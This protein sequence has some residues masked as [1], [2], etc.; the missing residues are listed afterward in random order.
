MHTNGGV[1]CA[2]GLTSGEQM[3]GSGSASLQDISG[4]SPNAKSAVPSTQASM[5][6]L[7]ATNCHLKEKL[8]EVKSNYESVCDENERLGESLRTAN[9]EVRKA[10]ERA[11]EATDA[12]TVLEGLLEEERRARR[13][14]VDKR[15]IAEREREEGYK[16]EME[17]LSERMRVAQQR[18]EEVENEF[19]SSASTIEDLQAAVAAGH[20]R[21]EALER[22]T[23]EVNEEM[24]A[25]RSK[26][27][28][29][30]AERL[31]LE[32]AAAELRSEC[33]KA[34]GEVSSLQ[35][36]L[37]GKLVDEETLK[38]NLVALQEERDAL[39]VTGG[40]I[41]ELTSNIESLQKD[42]SVAK[43][44][45]TLL[46]SEKDS[47][48]ASLRKDKETLQN[49]VKNMTEVQAEREESHET[50][51]VA[52]RQSEEELASLRKECLTAQEQCAATQ[53]KCDEVSSSLETS[54][55]GSLHL[56]A[57]ICA[58]ERR[59]CELEEE[60]RVER[61]KAKAVQEDHQKEVAAMR[62]DIK[63]SAAAL[64][65]EEAELQGAR[66]EYTVLHSSYQSIEE[67]LS[68]ARAETIAVREQLEQELTTGH[69][70]E[71]HSIAVLTEGKAALQRELDSTRHE[72][73]RSIE[74]GRR[75]QTL[76]GEQAAA[77]AALEGDRRD[78]TAQLT[79]L[80]AASLE[81]VG[82]Y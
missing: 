73:E 56:S 13:E 24:L 53:S 38:S 58:L 18:L 79:A 14:E 8:N 60:K 16:R 7:E 49:E 48:I 29:W 37:K 66:G 55:A 78:L 77:V 59:V 69:K 71:E 20:A 72:L 4:G 2:Q 47:L 25:L 65:A 9:N 57:S 6:E 75:D 26:E 28:K 50:I 68:E 17:V 33:E 43:E 11:E 30:T 61:V 81:K 80:Q 63:E 54:R 3:G 10:E 39:R 23:K 67:K 52:L 45:L 12:G 22:D 27:E 82:D 62:K 31:S 36:Q 44:A 46:S 74:D 40:R 5:V 64:R 76:L 41:P 42:L 51:A 70:D 21:E 34:Q 1:I 35:A 32:R 15:V 19:I